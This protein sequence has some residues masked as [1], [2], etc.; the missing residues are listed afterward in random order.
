MGGLTVIV[1]EREASA[2]IELVGCLR[3]LGLRALGL[4]VTAHAL[5]LLAALD[6]DV[7]LVRSDEE[8]AA[9]EPLRRRT[10]VV[11]VAHATPI[12][13]AVVTLLRALGRPDA[14]A[15]IN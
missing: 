7:A 3:R 8:P 13:D 12:A 5:A 2:R 15:L 4:D 6:A 11:H 9:L 10:A 14:A 1:I